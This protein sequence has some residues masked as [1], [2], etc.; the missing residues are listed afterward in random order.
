MRSNAQQ[1]PEL[2]REYPPP[3]EAEVAQQ[4]T[5]LLL[6]KVRGDYPSGIVRRD[7]HAKHHGCVKAEFQVEADLP[8]ELRVGIF[9]ES[10]TYPA[11]VRFSNQ[12]G[13]PNPDAKKDIRG[14]AIKLL[15][16]E[17]E[18]LLDDEKEERTQDFLL[19]SHPVFVTRDMAEFYRLIKASVS[20]TLSLIW[21]F[22]NPFDFHWRVYRNLTASLQRHANPL[23]IRYW[24]T[25]PYL[26]GS[27]AV[28]YSAR[29][30]AT[31][32]TPIPADPPDNYLKD[33]L[34]RSLEHGE[35]CFDF[36]IQFQ[37]DPVRMPIED[38]GALWSEEL[39]PFRKV[40]TVRIPAQVF[41]SPEQMAFGEY[42]SFTPWH[43]LPEHRP[44]GGINRARKVAYK[45]ISEFRH[46]MNKTSRKE[47]TSLDVSSFS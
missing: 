40:A 21:F 43:C 36:L 31:A 15:G 13:V 14:M 20:G 19:I 23:E 46:Q 38:P 32:T 9:R 22:F 47:P 44:L 16:V 5:E 45:T 42:I 25:T 29:P 41:D 12:D 2:A 17:G 30:Q 26:F 4:L 3:G 1:N 39:S 8:A 35:A 33:A 27:W 6:N 11:W 34:K 7:A 37:T 10:R 28:K 24:S 18:K